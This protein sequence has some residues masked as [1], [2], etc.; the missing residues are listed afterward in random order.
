MGWT[1]GRRSSRRPGAGRGVPRRLRSTTRGDGSGIA[2]SSGRDLTI[3][4]I[5]VNAVMAGCEPEHLPVLIA[6]AEILVDPHYGAEHSGNTTGADALIIVDGPNSVDLGF[7][8][9]AGRPA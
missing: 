5:A 1:D 2:A 9:G 8:H 6:L 4:S 3:W 7:N